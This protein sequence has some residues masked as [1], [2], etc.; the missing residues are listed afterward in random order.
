[1]SDTFA[2]ICDECI[3]LY[4]GSQFADSCFPTTCEMCGG[5]S[6]SYIGRREAIHDAKRYLK[7]QSIPKDKS[8]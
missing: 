7:A 2:Y 6:T 3:E 4:N 5:T 1:M 8:P